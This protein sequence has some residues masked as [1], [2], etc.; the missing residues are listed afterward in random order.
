M[1]VLLPQKILLLVIRENHY[2][3]ITSANVRKGSIMNT[4]T[5]LPE[6][7]FLRLTQIIGN[8]KAIPPIP[9]L[10]PVSKTSWWQRVKSGKFP[11]PVKLGARTTAWR[12]ED[13]RSYIANQNANFV[14]K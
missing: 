11:K 8:P 12:V 3:F 7:C 10:I 5:T 9:A 2:C 1:Q 14:T 13:I 6:T 4:P